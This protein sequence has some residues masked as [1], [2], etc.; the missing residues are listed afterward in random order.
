MIVWKVVAVL[1]CRAAEYRVGEFISGRVN[2]VS[3][4]GEGMRVLCCDKRVKHYVN[5]SGCGIFH[6]CRTVKAG[7][8]YAVLLILY[9]A[10]TNSN[11]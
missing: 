1:I 5:I 6:A 7:D 4:I 10:R 11:I 2:L 8:Y 3:P 9:G